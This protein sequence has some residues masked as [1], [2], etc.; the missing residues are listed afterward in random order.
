MVGYTSTKF[1]QFEIKIDEHVEEDIVTEHFSDT[2]K[3][4][5]KAL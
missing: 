3:W 1:Y 2:D 5:M 4:R